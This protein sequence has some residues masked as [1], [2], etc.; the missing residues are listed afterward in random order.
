LHETF[1]GVLCLALLGGLV[2]WMR[3]K[4]KHTLVSFFLALLS[5]AFVGLQA[6]FFMRYLGL[7]QDL[8]FALSGACGYS[9]GALLDAMTPL[10]IRWCHKRLGV[11]YPVPRRRAEDKSDAA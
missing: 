7:S 1:I 5:S 8:Q 3:G 6:H 9:A 10:M 4:N 11:E 2:R